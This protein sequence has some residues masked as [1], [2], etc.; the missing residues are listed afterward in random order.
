MKKEDWIWMPHPGHFCAASSCNFR[1]NT[2]V[3]EYIVST[4]GE[5]VPEANRRSGKLEELGWNRLYE[6]MVFRAIKSKDPCCPYRAD[7]GGGELDMEGYNT[8][9][10]ALKGHMALC[11]KW[12][13]KQQKVK[14]DVCPSGGE[15]AQELNERKRK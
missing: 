2:Y 11:L 13:K 1:M 15:V 14:N 4:V 12:S 7:V 10:D 6:T 5:Y 8:A 3:G 9:K